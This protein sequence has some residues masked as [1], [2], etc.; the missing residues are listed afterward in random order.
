MGRDRQSLRVIVVVAAVLLGREAHA[1]REEALDHFEQAEAYF[2]AGAFDEAVAEYR[3]AYALVPEPVLLFDIGL[4]LENHGDAGHAI[5]YYRRY[6]ADDPGGV[7]VAEARARL[8][9]LSD[10]LAA[11]KIERLPEVPLPEAPPPAPRPPRRHRRLP[12]AIVLA[13]ATALTAVGI[14]YQRKASRIRDELA[15]QLTDGTPPVD[16]MD[17]RFAEGEAA[18]RRSNLSLGVAGV[19]LVAGVTLV[20]VW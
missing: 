13:G 6:L 19:A 15:A 12:G 4:A 16:A 5:E 18:A 7:K 3:A 8:E 9:A 11:E 1:Q 10:R 17:P 14:A 2:R 20:V